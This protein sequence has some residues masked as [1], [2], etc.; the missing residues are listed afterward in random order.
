[1]KKSKCK[2]IVAKCLVAVIGLMMGHSIISC[3]LGK[4]ESYIHD[5]VVR[6]SSPHGMCSGEQVHSPSGADYIL[7][8]AHCKILSDNGNY[9]ITREDGSVLIRKQIAEDPNSDLMLLE[10]VPGL[11]GLDIA[12]DLKKNEHVR[13]FTHGKNMDTYKTEGEIIM[14]KEIQIMISIINS[15][16]EADACSK[17]PKNK[18]M[19]AMPPFDMIQACILDVKEV[20]MTAKI[21]PGSSGGPV[22]SD[23]GELLGVCSASDGDFNYIVD[24]SDIVKFLHAY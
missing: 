20:A 18:V 1:M 16:E 21:V 14:I 19:S 13:T 22:V 12:S 2:H 3:L 6:I 10:G 9:K 17:M 23:S 11:R 7:T 24:L 4:S 5:R 15:P 8:A